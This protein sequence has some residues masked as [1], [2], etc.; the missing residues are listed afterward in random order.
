MRCLN[1]GHELGGAE[2]F[3]PNCGVDLPRRDKGGSGART[4]CKEC[5]AAFSPEEALAGWEALCPKCAERH[6]AA[7]DRTTGRR[8]REKEKFLA[9]DRA[10]MRSQRKAERFEVAQCLVKISKTGFSA[11]LLGGE[12]ARGPLIDLST[13][14][15]QCVAAGSFAKGDKV[16]ITL[17]VPA[18]GSPLE[19]K[20]AVRWGVPE[21][22]DKTRVGVEFDRADDKTRAH[23]EAL[24]KHQALRDAALLRDRKTSSTQEMKAVRPPD[25]G[26]RPKDF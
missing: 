1:C 25:P 12:T 8:E 21:G 23:L 11:A 19:L 3:C 20:G 22:K 18:F 10:G 15:L 26:A 4:L 7:A 13:S 5:G 17:F 9:S 6:A 16:V 24:D 14:G 2:A